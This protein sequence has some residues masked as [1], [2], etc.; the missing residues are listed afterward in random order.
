MSGREKEHTKKDFF[1]YL[2]QLFEC[3]AVFERLSN[4][5]CTH[6]TDH[7]ETKATQWKTKHTTMTGEEERK[8]I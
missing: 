2:L 7:V 1:M 8:S 6:I 3:L 4:R 5:S